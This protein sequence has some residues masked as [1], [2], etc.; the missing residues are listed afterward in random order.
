MA[1]WII[2]ALMAFQKT[3][4]EFGNQFKGHQLVC[5]RAGDIPCAQAWWRSTYMLP[6]HRLHLAMVTSTRFIAL[7]SLKWRWRC[8]TQAQEKHCSPQPTS[9]PQEKAPQGSSTPDLHSKTT[10][11]WKLHDPAQEPRGVGLCDMDPSMAWNPDT[12]YG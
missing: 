7:I 4:S 8:Q 6:V 9:G 11:L 2:S 3:L 12:R 10:A 1:N 5:P